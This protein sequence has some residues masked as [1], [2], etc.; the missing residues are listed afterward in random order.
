MSTEQRILNTEHYNSALAY[1]VL[2]Q[3]SNTELHYTVGKICFVSSH[4][5]GSVTGNINASVKAVQSLRSFSCNY[6][7][8]L[9]VSI[10]K[11]YFSPYITLS[12]LTARPQPPDK[13]KGG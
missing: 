1:S 2:Y 6:L 12:N 13:R 11:S 3:V 4:A 8:T 7:A 5:S 10:L 9:Q